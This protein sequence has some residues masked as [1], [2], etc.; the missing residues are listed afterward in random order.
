MENN[1]CKSRYLK[2][3]IFD[4]TNDIKKIESRVNRTV[5]VLKENHAKIVSITTNIYGIS[6][7]NL[8]YNIIYEADHEIKNDRKG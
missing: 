3:V 1:R 6:P 7:M 5:D 8:I 2:T 4:T